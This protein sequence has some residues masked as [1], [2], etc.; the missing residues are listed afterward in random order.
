[1]LVEESRGAASDVRVE[2]SAGADP[3]RTA[4]AKPLYKKWWLWTTLGIVVAGA[5]AGTAIALTRNHD[6]PEAY[7]GTTMSVLQGP[8][9]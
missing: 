2:T 3:H 4:E 7:G 1:V 9:Q 5:A 8:D 6:Q